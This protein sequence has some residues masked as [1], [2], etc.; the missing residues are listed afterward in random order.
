[1]AQVKLY[2]L[3]KHLNPIKQAMSDVTHACVTE[4]LG[5]PQDKRAHRFFA[6]EED[7]FLMPGGRSGAYTILEITMISGREKA[8]KKR[9]VQRLFHEFESR[10]NIAPMDLEIC[11]Y[12]CPPENWGFRGYNGDEVKLS[13]DI[14]V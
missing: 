8:T 5:L 4:V 14:K 13:Y 9:L 2:G 1:M 11:I 6:M 7:S 10:L 12:E 3:A